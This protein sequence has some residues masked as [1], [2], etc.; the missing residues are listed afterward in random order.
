MADN[1]SDQEVA[2]KVMHKIEK[3]FD[4]GDESGKAIFDSFL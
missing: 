4:D 2:D 3:F 1:L